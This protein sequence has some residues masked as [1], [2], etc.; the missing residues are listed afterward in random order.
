MLS[1]VY[2]AALN[3][4]SL[5]NKASGFTLLSVYGEAVGTVAKLNFTPVEGA[6]AYLIRRDGKLLGTTT[7]LEYT[8]EMPFGMHTYK[9]EALVG[10][11]IISN[12]TVRLANYTGLVYGDMDSDGDIDVKDALIL[13]SDILDGRK[14]NATLV[15]VIRLMRCVF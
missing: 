3:P 5:A 12:D 13:I 6:A 2:T 8:D 9:V 14:E 10:G 15:D 1:K 4:L 7:N 11:K